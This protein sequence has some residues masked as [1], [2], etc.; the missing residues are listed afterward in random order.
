MLITRWG[1]RLC[2]WKSI[3]RLFPTKVQLRCL[4]SSSWTMA[5]LNVIHHWRNLF[6]IIL[7]LRFNFIDG[8]I[9]SWNN[10]YVAFFVHEAGLSFESV[11]ELV[12]VRLLFLNYLGNSSE[13]WFD[14]RYEYVL[15]VSFGGRVC[16][17]SGW[18]WV[19]IRL[20]WWLKGLLCTLRLH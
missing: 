4:Q 14:L 16:R 2:L 15:V 8:L 17:W 19:Q 1:L 11:L 12:V 18:L 10:P 7:L 13:L 9:G 3:R 6:L 20:A 5:N